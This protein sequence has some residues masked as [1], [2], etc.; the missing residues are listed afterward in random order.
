MKN[1]HKIPCSI[2]KSHENHHEVPLNHH[3][4]TIKSPWNRHKI[5]SHENHHDFQ[6]ARGWKSPW[7]PLS[8]SRRM[9]TSWS[10]VEGSTAVTSSESCSR[11]R[12]TWLRPQ[13]FRLVNY[14]YLPIYIIYIYIYILIMLTNQ[15]QIWNN[16]PRYMNI[17]IWEWWLVGV[18]IPRWPQQ[19]LDFFGNSWEI[20]WKPR[21]FHMEIPMCWRRSWL[22]RDFCLGSMISG[23]I[24]IFH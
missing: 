10:S 14:H 6:P 18:T 17:Y 15:D 1:H 16:L 9:R 8:D 2:I 7:N 20:W 23:Q 3:W 12:R 21:V 5:K 19:C 22:S 24:V 11:A 4:I 13:P